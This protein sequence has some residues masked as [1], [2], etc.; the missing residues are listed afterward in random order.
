MQ[1]F[2]QLVEIIRYFGC[3]MEEKPFSAPTQNTQEPPLQNA[4]EAPTSTISP[5]SSINVG[6]A[7][8]TINPPSVDYTVTNPTISTVNPAAQTI[9]LNQPEKGNTVS[10][11]FL[12]IGAVV[13]VIGLGVMGLGV[14][15]FGDTLGKMDEIGAKKV[16]RIQPLLDDTVVFSSDGSTTNESFEFDTDLWYQIRVEHGATINSISIL[17]ENNNTLLFEEKC[18]DSNPE[19]GIDDCKDYSTFDIGSIDVALS[20]GSQYKQSI[21]GTINIDAT[22][23]VTINNLDDEFF[24]SVFDSAA[25]ID[26]EYFAG[27]TITIFFGACVG[28][29]VSPIGLLVG[30]VIRFA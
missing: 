30:I 10:N 28:C 11:V 21:N 22:G 23:N 18:K 8:N 9:M 20:E 14:I 27:P 25:L 6:A 17:D 16:L 1:L 3:R 2:H 19:D 4:Q 15:Q 26:E 24:E 13:L 5:P 12:I 29:C 7:S